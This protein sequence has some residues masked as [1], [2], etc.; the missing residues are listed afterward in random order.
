MGIIFF[1]K[2]IIKKKKQLEIYQREEMDY[3]IT[4]GFREVIEKDVL[5][6]K[7]MNIYVK[8]KSCRFHIVTKFYWS[9]RL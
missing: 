9:N 4:I 7:E 6:K 3:D 5:R 2:L 1:S 8:G